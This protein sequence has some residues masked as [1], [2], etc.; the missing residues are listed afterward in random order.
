MNWLRRIRLGLRAL[1]RRER[2]EAEIEAELGTHLELRT[3]QNLDAGMEPQEARFAA[4]RQF[5]WL[6]S[7]REA[8][9]RERG[10]CWLEDFRLDARHGLRALRKGLRFTLLAVVTLGLGIGCTTA[11]LTLL[12]RLLL[13]PFP[14]GDLREWVL[15]H[16]HHPAKGWD[17]VSSPLLRELT[18]QTN[19]FRSVCAFRPLTIFLRGPELADRCTGFWTTANFFDAL[20]VPALQGRTYRADEVALGQDDALVVS[21]DF[22]R[23]RYPNSPSA[24]GKVLLLDKKPHR[25]IGVMP[26]SFQFP[27]GRDHSEFWRPYPF[28]AADYESGQRSQR[29]WEVLAHLAPGCGIAQPR[30][31]LAALATRLAADLPPAESGWN[32]LEVLPT[33]HL[34]LSLELHQA[35]LGLLVGSLVVLLLSSANVANVWLARAEARRKQL[36]LQVAIGA[37]RW[38]TYRQLT[39]EIGLLVAASLPLGLAVAW[40]MLALTERFAPSF[41]PRLRELGVDGAVLGL[42]VLVALAV[43]AATAL[44][45]AWSVWHTRLSEVLQESGPFQTASARRRG[46]LSALAAAELALAA[47]L[48]AATGVLVQNAIKRLDVDLGFDPKGQMFVVFESPAFSQMNRA[49]HDALNAQLE[50]RLRALPGGQAVASFS[51]SDRV[52]CRAEEWQKW[53][54]MSLMGVGIGPDFLA[55]LG[56]PL[57][58]GRR[59]QAADAFSASRSIIL[60]QE[61]AR[62]LWPGQNPL[63]KQLW[64]AAGN[65]WERLEVV[66]VVGN[67]KH[68]RVNP[69][70]TARRPAAGGQGA[71]QDWPLYEPFQPMAY[72]PCE[73]RADPGRAFLIR[74]PSDPH[75]LSRPIRAVSRE[76]LSGD[77]PPSAYFLE[78]EVAARTR[79][80]RALLLA[81]GLYAAVVFAVSVLGLYGALA[82]SVTQRTREIGIRLAL[83]ATPPGILRNVLGEAARLA[84]AGLGLGLAGGILFA[85]LAPFPLLRWSGANAWVLL[86]APCL[87]ALATWLAG[88][89]PA[90]RAARVDPLAALRYE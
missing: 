65:P 35:L 75:A 55:T 14:G 17:F 76:T 33:R 66:G 7:I 68:W 20:G 44:G 9:R 40:G 77:L 81:L 25:I 78:E 74:A 56:V 46:V 87:A 57:R 67:A 72:L 6:D 39:V 69:V 1:F 83:G 13:R 11:V 36:A 51:G 34:F 82:A 80:P 19:L 63:G 26:R 58:T 29:R 70:F 84:A 60:N 54:T 5:G 38:R 24:V 49:R 15:I 61:A 2:L 90:R 48:L 18:S 28:K 79:I 3:Q 73:R 86:A 59:F 45:P 31:Q 53:K 32:G 37:G 22:W 12:D 43:C 64:L 47:F 89:G 21:Y 52:R 88:Y 42:A 85:R 50:R 10:L 4:L 23:R 8:C 30:Q 71:I 41:L 62:Q 16:E 27:R